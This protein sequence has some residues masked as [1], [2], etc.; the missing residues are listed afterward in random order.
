[1]KQNMG[2][3]DRIIRILAAAV[4]AILYVTNLISGTLAL[5]LGLVAVIFL[6]T[7]AVSFCPL[8]V[9]FK[10]STKKS[11]PEAK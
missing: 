9:P 2:S 5:I 3:T 8:Y 4:I 6:I 11:A 10:L 1:M 7:S